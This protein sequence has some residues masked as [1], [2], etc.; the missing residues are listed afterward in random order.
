[1]NNF[2]KKDSFTGFQILTA[3]LV[4]T[5][6]YLI[7]AV[8][9]TDRFNR[10]KKVINCRKMA[11]EGI[12]K[13]IREGRLLTRKLQKKQYEI[14]MNVCLITLPKIL[15]K[16]ERINNMKKLKEANK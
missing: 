9:W 14:E 3:F 15:E 11:K 5:V 4:P 7:F 6:V 16:Q 2:F 13:E 10:N 1:M 12:A 8:D